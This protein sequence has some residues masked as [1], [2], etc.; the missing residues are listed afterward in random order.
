ME[1]IHC[2]DWSLTGANVMANTSQKS[3]QNTPTV[4]AIIDA[5]TRLKPFALAV[6]H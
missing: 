5:V 6:S 1:T 3:R 4:N 2:A